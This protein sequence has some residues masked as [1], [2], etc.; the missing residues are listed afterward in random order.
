MHQYSIFEYLDTVPVAGQTVYFA[1][2]GEIKKIIITEI[3][4]Y[5]GRVGVK[6]KSADGS[7]WVLGKW[8]YS[9]ESAKYDIFYKTI[10][11]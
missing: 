1:T 7:I 10:R 5:F 3:I 4:D 9:E 11:H 8:Y 6:G 2:C